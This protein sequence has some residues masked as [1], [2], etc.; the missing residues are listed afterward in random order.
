MCDKEKIDFLSKIGVPARQIYDNWELPLDVSE[1][2]T[3][4]PTA[5]YISC[6]KRSKNPEHHLAGESQIDGL[7]RWFQD[8]FVKKLNVESFLNFKKDD[9]PMEA[10]CKWISTN[11]L[12]IFMTNETLMVQ[13]ELHPRLLFLD[14]THCVSTDSTKI[15]HPG[16]NIRM[17]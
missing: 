15:N 12:F 4:P 14:A 3:K 7:L 9:L 16:H 17:Y 6:R 8:D 11:R 2:K 5:P 1:V 13:F 10:Q